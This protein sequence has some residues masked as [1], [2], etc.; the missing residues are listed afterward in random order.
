MSKS[1]TLGV[2]IGATLGSSFS[3]A[4]NGANRSLATIGETTEKLSQTRLEIKEFRQLSK[5]AEANSG[6]LMV[7]GQSLKR[8]GVDV[9]NLDRE[10]QRLNSTLMNLKK[11]SR[12]RI[13]ID[14]NKQALDEAKS[15]LM[16]VAA[17]LYSIGKLVSARGEIMKAQGEIASLGIDEAG[18]ASI[19]SVGTA[20]SST[21]AGTNTADFV[22][23]SYDVKS[24]IVTLG[25]VAVGEFTRIAALTAAATKSTTSEMTTL[26]AKGYGIYRNQ[27]DGFGQQV[28]AGWNSLSDEERDIEFGKY[29]S[30]GISASVQSFR[31]DGAQMS[32]ALGALGATATT[33]GASF[34]DQLSVLGALQR[35]MGGSEAATKYRSFLANAS[36]AGNTLGLDFVDGATGMLRSVPEILDQIHASYGGVID[37]SAKDELRAAFGDQEALALVDLL[38]SQREA[39]RSGAQEINTA[40][41][42]GLDKTEAMAKAM[43]RG[44]GFELLGQQIGNLS[45]AVGTTLYPTA[46]LLAGVVGKV[47]TGLQWLGERFPVVTGTTVGLTVGFIGVLAAAKALTVGVLF[48]KGGWLG[49]QAAY[50][51]T[52]AA[53]PKVALALTSVSRALHLSTIS[54][55]A[56]AGA[57]KVWALGSVMVV[58]ATRAVSL[59]FRAMSVAIMS[60]PLG[61][62]IAGIAVAAGL[63]IAYWEPIKGFFAGLW[64]SVKSLFADGVS[65]LMSVW[66]K[67]PLGMLF[68]A[69]EKLAGFVGG[70]FGRKS[71]EGSPQEEEA[72]TKPQRGGLVRTAQAVAVG[73]TLVASPVAATEVALPPLMPV[74]QEAAPTAMP[75]MSGRAVY[76]PELSGLPAVS[77]VSGRAVYSPELSGLPAVSDVSGRAVY[78]PELSGLPAV[79]DVSGRAVYSPELSGLPAV[80]D[81]SGRAVYSP[82]LSGLPAVSDVSG[83]AVYSPELSG[84]PAVSDVSGRAVYSPELSGLP[85]V[86][87]VSGRAVYSPELSGLPAVSD[88]SGRAVYSPE[89]SGLPAVSDVSGRAVYSPELAGLPAPVLSSLSPAPAPA[90]APAAAAP[91]TSSATTI[92]NNQRYEIKIEVASGADAQAIAREVERVLRERD[93]A[94]GARSRG[95]LYD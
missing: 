17:S 62:A 65:F 23:A 84:L 68:T 82:E 70:L 14:A 21:W 87:D 46:E 51:A 2:V 60:N 28:V 9:S 18:I 59:G 8:A 83:R 55:W 36:K 91:V 90:P 61:L 1:L 92:N 74:T 41:S 10:S 88:V 49:L 4:M 3:A 86:S 43:Q 12:I 79:S 71:S 22:R 45:A 53:S 15:G 19:T 72:A 30:A 7:L 20:F 26:F 63:V 42:G 27:F 67:S 40:L 85:A 77:D 47:A 80:S 81:V 73:A 44:R 31:T 58:S 35:T 37:Q 38:V 32:Q 52:L 24:G 54:T 64:G 76:S 57:Q 11:Q 13:E 48:L 33:A 78:S 16:G 6:R 50:F 56:L 69:G 93:A 25:D 66:E 94:A 95:R 34:A 29:F 89:L 75:K 39:L 5:D